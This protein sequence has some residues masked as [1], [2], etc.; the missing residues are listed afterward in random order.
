M[1]LVGLTG[2]I[3]S[4]KSTVARLLANKGLYVVDADELAREVVEP[5]S[6][7]LREIFDAFGGAV[8]GPDGQLDR[9]AL[10]QLVFSDEGKRRQLEAITH[11]RIF[12]RFQARTAAAQQRGE[13][14]VVYDAP[15]L[16]ERQLDTLMNAVVV[17][18]VPEAVQK[19]RLRLRDG[20]SDD[21]IELR[22]R[23]QMPLGDKVA[24][25]D[26]VI[27]NSRTLAHTEAQVDFI[28]Q[29]LMSRAT[30]GAR[31]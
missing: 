5:G 24:R 2:G 20:L 1:L 13:T 22:L 3:G 7:A 27:D 15:L 30:L 28:V 14:V 11:P 6:P 17:V 19:E 18:T 31:G 9:K 12:E 26:F 25:A 10:G 21:E 16:Y 4:G 29:Q 8:F 23:S